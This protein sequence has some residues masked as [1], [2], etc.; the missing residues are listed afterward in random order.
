MFP[1]HSFV[2][3]N[4]E[5]W[6]CLVYVKHDCSDWSL[7]EGGRGGRLAV[8]RKHAL[9][10]AVG[11]V[12]HEGRVRVTNK[13]VRVSKKKGRQS[14]KKCTSL[15]RIKK[16]GFKKQFEHESEEW[17]PDSGTSTSI[18]AG[19]ARLMHALDIARPTPSSF[20]YA[21]AVSMWR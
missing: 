3:T 5:A 17:D 8:S 4:S 15:K 6:V 7:R 9:S 19:R 18:G 21:S 1:G 10:T 11:R 2:V 14:Y 20:L 12:L 16:T 13:E